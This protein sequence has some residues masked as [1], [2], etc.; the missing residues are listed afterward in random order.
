MQNGQESLHWCEICGVKMPKIPCVRSKS[1][2]IFVSDKDFR[3]L[4]R[5]HQRPNAC[6]ETFD[7]LS[8]LPADPAIRERIPT[9][10]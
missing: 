3:L 10:L 6:P 9:P 4:S 2:K 8:Q 1:G 5:I 7:L